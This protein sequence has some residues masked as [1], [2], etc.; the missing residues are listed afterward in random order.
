MSP[1]TKSPRGGIDL[2]GTKIQAVVV[3][4]GTTMSSARRAARRR[5]RAARRTSPRRWSARCRT[6][7]ATPA[8]S[9]ARSP[10]SASARPARSTRRPGRS[11]RRA[12]FPGWEG[13][14]ALGAVLSEDAR[15]AG[16]AG[17]RRRRRH[18]R[19]VQARRGRA[20]RLAARRLLGHRRRRRAVLDGKHW[21]G[22]GGAGEIGHMVIK[23][24]GRRC[25]CGR[26]G[27]HGGLRRARRD[28]G[29][30]RASSRRRDARR[31]SSRSWRSAGATGSPAASGSGR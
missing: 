18:R 23:L 27:L 30:G 3:D 17:Q 29:P 22:R 14:F 26:R 9:P 19:R 16:Q 13:T 28:G 25:P 1:S 10:A 20:L 21:L 15:R 12:T 4:G 31:T 2:G 6:R 24:G 11:R 5:R 8:S 7:S